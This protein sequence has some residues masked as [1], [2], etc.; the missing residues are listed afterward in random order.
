M[1]DFRTRTC[2][3]CGAAFQAPR[4]TGRPPE[5]CSATCRRIAARQRQSAYIHRLIEARK[6]LS[7]IQAA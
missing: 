6:Q 4:T 3:T 5:K 7:T 1:S 2:T